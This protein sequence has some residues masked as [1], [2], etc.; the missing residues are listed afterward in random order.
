MI[1]LEKCY[2]PEILAI[3]KN[4]V[5]DCEVRIFGSRYF[6]TSK[7]YSDMDLALVCERK[8]DESVIDKLKEEF[9]GSDIPFRVDIL[10][11]NSAS[12]EFRKII[13]NGYGVIQRASG[14]IHN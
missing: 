9:A 12:P 10:N 3:L 8:I 1:E 11:F 4:N 7:E 2:F 6:G 13:E 14:E 5:P